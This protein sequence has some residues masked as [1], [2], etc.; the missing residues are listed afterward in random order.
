MRLRFA[1]ATGREVAILSLWT[2]RGTLLLSRAHARAY[3]I[4]ELCRVPS[5]PFRRLTTA[6]EELVSYMHAYAVQRAFLGADGM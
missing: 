5:W 1:P 2:I 3:D 4:Q 6:H